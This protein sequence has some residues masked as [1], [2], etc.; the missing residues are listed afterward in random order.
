MLAENFDSVTYL[1]DFF[2]FG[3]FSCD[4]ISIYLQYINSVV[5][6]RDDQAEIIQL[7]TELK[8]N[9]EELKVF[10][11]NALKRLS[12]EKNSK[13]IVI[14]LPEDLRSQL[15]KSI[16]NFYKIS[17]TLKELNYLTVSS[18]E[19]NTNESTG[20]GGLT[21]KK[22]EDLSYQACDKVYL[23]DDNGPY[24]NLRNSINELHRTLKET[25]SGLE[26]GLYEK[27]L[28]EEEYKVSFYW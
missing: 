23:I 22:L 8:N 10:M 13:M 26:A 4:S 15:E 21:A 18:S 9:N 3:T 7:L 17:K 27:E 1:E 5:Q 25:F 2:T 24:E 14:C 16:V 6:V 12:D 19:Y 20:E 28:N 11:R